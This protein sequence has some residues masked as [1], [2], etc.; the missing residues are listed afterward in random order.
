M[1]RFFRRK[2]L[3]VSC[4]VLMFLP[5]ASCTTETVPPDFSAAR[6]RELAVMAR[7]ESVYDVNRNGGIYLRQDPTHGLVIRAGVGNVM[8]KGH[9]FNG[10]VP[11]EFVDRH[12]AIVINALAEFQQMETL[13]LNSLPSEHLQLLN[14]LT[15]L[16]RL[17]LDVLNKSVP[18]FLSR[19]P[20]IETL[21][22]GSDILTVENLQ[23]LGTAKHLKRLELI[24]PTIFRNPKDHQ[25]YDAIGSLIQLDSL[26]LE[27]IE[28]SREDLKR[29][30]KLP[31]KRLRL[32]KLKVPYLGHNVTKPD[33]Y[34]HLADLFEEIGAFSQLEELEI[35]IQTRLCLKTDLFS[36]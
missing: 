8:P 9:S 3:L 32:S 23:A 35:E 33:P 30:N 4:L 14:K 21:V 5:V 19:R 12:K 17:E 1:S 6:T 11:K 22:I 7:L 36:T 2:A 28:I 15:R 27:L 34:H 18:E 13:Y 26:R 29:L 24:C 16:K 31:L 20:Q 25:V 10:K